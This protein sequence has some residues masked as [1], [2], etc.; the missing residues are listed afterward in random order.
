M[1]PYA[2]QSFELQRPELKV[3]G[4]KLCSDCRW[5]FFYCMK[6]RNHLQ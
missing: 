2:T 6:T 5:V 3:V 4:L 1:P